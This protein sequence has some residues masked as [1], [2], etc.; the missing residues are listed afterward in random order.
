MLTTPIV[1][2]P[3]P[4]LGDSPNAPTQML[5]QAS[6][7][8]TVLV[9]RFASTAARD[10]AIT[11]PLVGQ[12]CFVTFASGREFLQIYSSGAWVNLTWSKTIVM[13]T[14]SLRTATV[15]ITPDA[16]FQF[17][18][19]ANARYMLEFHLHVDNTAANSIDFRFGLAAPVGSVGNLHV[20]GPAVTRTSSP[21]PQTM[22]PVTLNSQYQL[23]APIVGQYHTMAANLLIGGTAGTVSLNW[24][25]YVSSANSTR[26]REGS[27]MK[28]TQI[29]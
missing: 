4:E 27:F 20:R 25:Q 6:A 7:L 21:N 18:G 17:S 22:L 9:P 19:A 16:T 29:A 2:I 28:I 1:G 11:A 26:I 10:A 5:N 24:A 12:V 8:D 14:A 15:T 13:E 3:Y 23:A